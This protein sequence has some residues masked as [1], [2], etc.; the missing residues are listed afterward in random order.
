MEEEFEDVGFLDQD[1]LK[2]QEKKIED[3]EITCN[4][5]SPEDCESCSG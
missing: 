3:G 2:K 5:D 4:I 1:K